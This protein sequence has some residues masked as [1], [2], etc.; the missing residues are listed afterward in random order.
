MRKTI[1]R[2]HTRRGLDLLALPL[3]AAVLAAA[4]WRSWRTFR[5]STDAPVSAPVA[6]GPQGWPRVPSVSVLV[7]AWNEAGHI[8]RLIDSFERLTYPSTE[9]VICAGG[10]DGTHDLAMR[11]SSDRVRVLPQAPGEGKQAALRHSYAVATGEV[12]VLTDADCQLVDEA[13]WRLLAPIA[14]GEA[15]VVTGGSEPSPDQRRRGLVQYQWLLDRWWHHQ[16]PAETDGLLGRNCALT[17]QALDRVG[18]FTAEARTGTD[19][20]LAHLLRQDG[21]RIRAVPES[22]VISDYP[23][24]PAAYLRMYER[25]HKNLLIHGPRFAAWADVRALLAAFAAY[26]LTVT[27]PLAAPLLGRIAVVGPAA[28]VGA[29]ILQRVARAGAGARLAGAPVSPSL[30][31]SAV[32]ATFLDIAAVLLAIYAAL[33]PRRRGRW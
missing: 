3:G 9:L 6:P 21:V 33:D 31:A 28:R 4:A 26:G 27:L 22:R 2:E 18:G 23:A 15:A 32:L 16:L 17:R 7:A 29:A 5:A 14:L 10:S 13:F 25:W 19:Y 24:E 30:V 1:V 11:R 8:D 12:I 20:V